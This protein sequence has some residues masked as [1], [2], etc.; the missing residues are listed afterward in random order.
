MG[1]NA[2]TKSTLTV[3]AGS[4][5]AGAIDIAATGATKAVIN[6]EAGS[7]ITGAVTDTADSTDFDLVVQGD[8]TIGSSQLSHPLARQDQSPSNPPCL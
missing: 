4:T 6:L 7:S 2:T 8:A 3:K 1:A 5:V